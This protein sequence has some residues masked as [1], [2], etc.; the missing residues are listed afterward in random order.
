MTKINNVEN[1]E[2]MSSQNGPYH[3]GKARFEIFFFFQYA[4]YEKYVKYAEYVIHNFGCGG[5]RSPVVWQ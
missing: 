4:Q 2:N 5:K 3:H 1:I